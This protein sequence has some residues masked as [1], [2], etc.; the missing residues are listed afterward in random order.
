MTGVLSLATGRAEHPWAEELM[1]YLRLIAD[2]FAAALSL[3]RAETAKHASEQLNRA[4][5]DSLA[6]PTAILDHQGNILKVTG[7]WRAVQREDGTADPLPTEAGTN[8]L[9]VCLQ[10]GSAGNGRAREVVEGLQAV[11][12]GTEREYRVRPKRSMAGGEHSLELIVASLD[13]P[14]GGAIVTQVDLTER[15]R[16]ERE[17]QE[18]R[19]TMTHV[20]RVAGLAELAGSLAHELNQPLTA[21]LSNVQAARRFL[22]SG[23]AASGEFREI[24]A[25]IEEDDKRAGEIIR[26]LR[27]LIRKEA[28]DHRAVSL[29]DL[30]VQVTKLLA[31]DLRLRHIRLELDFDPELPEVRADPMALQQVILNLMMNAE[32]AMQQAIP[33]RR[34]L[35][36]RTWQPDAQSVALAVRDYGTGIP[37]ELQEQIFQAFYTTKKEGLGIGLAICGSILTG[38]GGRIWALNNLDGGATVQFSLPLHPAAK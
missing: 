37:E 28:I 12:R 6:V 9:D 34:R 3:N 4:L 23:T 11:L 20:G 31:A 14:G 25:D 18:L 32:D 36:I 1:V 15:E 7:T 17:V 2:L 30:A 38:H 13:L 16:A 10:A 33:E 22:E 29:N 35:V 8:Y 19:H 27:A 21:I 5:L 24:L 26:R